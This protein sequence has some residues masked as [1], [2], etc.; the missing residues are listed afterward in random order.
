MKPFLQ[1]LAEE[2]AA[3]YSDDPGQLCVVLP[4]RR[5]GLYL[6]KYLAAA[7]KKTAWSPETYSVEDFITSISGLQIIDPAGLLFEFYHVHK[8]I[9]G[10]KAQDF[11][12]FADWGQVLL[13]D[14]D[15]IDQYLV[16]PEKIFTFLNAAR[17]YSVWNLNERPLTDQEK[18]Y[19]D[20][21]N[22]FLIYYQ[23]LNRR[24][25]EKKLVYQGLAYRVAADNIEKLSGNF[26]MEENLF[27]RF[28]CTFRGRGKDHRFPGPSG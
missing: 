11:D 23:H 18:N 25:T 6:K 8:E 10:D 9:H 24:L 12:V 21:Y 26:H 2:I 7:L 22:S 14:F 17:A 20:F 1:R 27:C 28:E 5:A 16:D 15:E 13:Q 4:N 19:I 3:R